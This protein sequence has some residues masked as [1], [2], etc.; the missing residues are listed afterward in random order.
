[1]NKRI[2]WNKGLKGV[3]KSNKGSFK[4][5]LTPWNKG[6]GWSKIDKYRK[7]FVKGMGNE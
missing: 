1:M 3:C 7:K 5:G 4:K 2:A 6:K